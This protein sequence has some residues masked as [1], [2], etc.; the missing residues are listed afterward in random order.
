LRLLAKS[1]RVADPCTAAVESRRKAMTGRART[2]GDLTER[3]RRGVLT[4]AITW[5]SGLRR[6]T[7]QLGSER[8]GWTLE[9]ARA[10]VGPVIARPPS[11]RR[12]EVLE[13]CATAIE[14]GLGEE[15]PDLL[16]RADG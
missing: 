12:R 8:D 13:L 16:G 14:I 7:V 4:F 2:S 11:P 9:M 3:E 15:L 10:L 5:Q 1:L 6:H